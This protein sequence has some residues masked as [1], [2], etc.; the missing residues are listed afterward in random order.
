ML[1]SFF[2]VLDGLYWE[3]KASSATWTFFMAPDPDEMNADPQPTD[4]SHS[5]ETWLKGPEIL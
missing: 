3:P 2:E 4:L 1:S 5:P